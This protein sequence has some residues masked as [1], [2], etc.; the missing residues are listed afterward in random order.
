MA[1]E[2]A[3]GRGEVGASREQ[4]P[5]KGA[6]KGGMSVIPPRLCSVLIGINSFKTL[7]QLA[8]LCVLTYYLTASLLEKGVERVPCRPDP[9][10]SPVLRYV[11]QHCY[12]F[13]PS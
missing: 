12:R 1:K 3:V 7:F 10:L 2:E 8:V 11:F 9:T 5:W 6:H 13:L 4:D